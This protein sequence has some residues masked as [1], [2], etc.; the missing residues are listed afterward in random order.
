MQWT[1]P[2]VATWLAGIGT[3]FAKYGEEFVASGITGAFLLDQVEE[4][5]LLDLSVE[6]KLHRKRIMHS[7]IEIKLRRGQ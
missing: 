5:D 2:E 3:A 7:I 6:S 1:D 4:G